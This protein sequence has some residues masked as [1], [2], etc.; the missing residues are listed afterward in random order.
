MNIP[1]TKNEYP[2]PK[3]WFRKKSYCTPLEQLKR[4]VSTWTQK[5][6]ENEEIKM[7]F[8]GQ[9]D[10]A[11]NNSSAWQ[12]TSRILRPIC[13]KFAVNNRRIQTGVKP[14]LTFDYEKS[15]F[16]TTSVH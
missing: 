6:K 11:E 7:C 12:R 9:N 14:E 1:H 3:V 8:P 5:F 15:S 4:N 16:F 10:S 2:S 13:G